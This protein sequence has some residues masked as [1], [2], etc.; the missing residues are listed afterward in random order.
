MGLLSAWNIHLPSFLPLIFLIPLLEKVLQNSKMPDSQ[1]F[2]S[3]QLKVFKLVKAALVHKDWDLGI[4][5]PPN[6]S[7]DEKFQIKLKVHS[8]WGPGDGKSVT[9]SFHYSSQKQLQPRPL[10]EVVPQLHTYRRDNL[11]KL[12]QSFKIIAIATM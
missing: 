6:K 7:G 12:T 1:T 10:L 9:P 4:S 8:L 2:Q 11:A 3:R 5:G